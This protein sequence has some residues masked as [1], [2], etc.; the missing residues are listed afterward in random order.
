VKN[1]LASFFHNK[2]TA[3]QTVVHRLRKL[4]KFFENSAFFQKHEVIGSSLLI[5]YTGDKAGVWMIDFAKTLPL[6]TTV[7]VD[8][9]RS[10]QMGNHEDGYLFGLDNL[11]SVLEDVARV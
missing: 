7:E 11:I 9:R 2:K 4:R 3:C 10:W 6:P 5:I 1:T 8:H